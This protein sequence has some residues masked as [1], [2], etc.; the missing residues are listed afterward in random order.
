MKNNQEKV[1]SDSILLALLLHINKNE[2]FCRNDKDFIS[3]PNYAYI[4]NINTLVRI[5]RKVWIGMDFF[6]TGRSVDRNK[7]D[8][9]LVCN[10][11]TYKKWIIML[12]K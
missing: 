9:S 3:L 12:K 11:W 1:I 6:T 10:I 8:S 4:V 7:T 5:K 2:H